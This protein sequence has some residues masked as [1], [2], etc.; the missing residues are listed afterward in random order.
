MFAL[1]HQYTVPRSRTRVESEFKGYRHFESG[2]AVGILMEG[3]GLT[4]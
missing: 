3:F 1:M 4:C 2:S